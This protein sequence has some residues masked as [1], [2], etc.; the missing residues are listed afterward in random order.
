[1]TGQQYLKR[2]NAP[3]VLL[4][5]DA[6]QSGAAS[7]EG[8]K[9]LDK[10]LEAL[11]YQFKQSSGR[12]IMTSSKPDEYSREKPSLNH[13]IFTYYLLRG[14]RGEADTGRTGMITLQALYDYVYAHTKDESDGLQ[15]PQYEGK[16]VGT[17]PLAASGDSKDP[18]QLEVEVVAQDPRCTN[19]LC[20]D[21]PGGV[22]QCSDPRCGDVGVPEGS[23]MYS[24]QNYQV[25]FRAST[26]CHVY[27]YQVGQDGEIFRLF[28]GTQYL[29]EDNQLRNP[30]PSGRIH[31]IPARDRWLRLDDSSGTEKIYVVASRTRNVILEDLYAHLEGLRKQSGDS[32]QAKTVGRELEGCLRPMGVTSIT[33]RKA[34]PFGMPGLDQKTRLFEEISRCF[35]SSRGL[36]AMKA[37]LIR[38]E[39]R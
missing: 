30:L 9:S 24:G 34:E 19:R 26:D 8:R 25:G 1:M 16:V 22:T 6:C 36:D 4:I 23:V 5:A 2:L 31:W 17:F 10:S 3:R 20:T 37:I 29:A 15:H 14:L 7:E 28:P 38:H 13:S 27:V 39:G 12:V 11:I 21:P 32:E 18:I 35:Y 33:V